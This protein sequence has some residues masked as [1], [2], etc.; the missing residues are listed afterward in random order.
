LIRTPWGTVENIRNEYVARL[1]SRNLS[2]L[3]LQHVLKASRNRKIVFWGV[4]GVFAKEVVSLFDIDY[5]Q[6]YFIDS[7]PDFIGQIVYGLPV[8][9]P[10]ILQ[11]EVAYNIFVIVISKSYYKEISHKLRDLKFREEIDFIDGRRLLLEEDGG[12]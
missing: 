7:N 11:E 6:D 4:G 10:S 2:M 5:N 12:Y 9:A 1:Q 3:A 8:K